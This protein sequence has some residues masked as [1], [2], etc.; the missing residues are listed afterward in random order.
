MSA[1]EDVCTQYVVHA[2]DVDRRFRCHADLVSSSS[3]RAVMHPQLRVLG[4]R[5]R[6][7]VSDRIAS[8]KMERNGD[9]IGALAGWRLV[10]KP[11]D[12]RPVASYD[13]TGRSG[14]FESNRLVI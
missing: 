7:E 3:Q 13:S 1:R 5:A 14:D 2:L 8:V 11:N 12:V 10:D 4:D 6:G 9:D